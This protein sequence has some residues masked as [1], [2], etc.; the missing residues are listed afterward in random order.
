MTRR[1]AVEVLPDADAVYRTA[2]ESLVSAAVGAVEQ[3]G[4]FVVVLAG[5]STPRDLHAIL[6]EPPHR[7]RVPWA[8]TWVLFGDERCVPPDDP[9]SNYRMA[10][11]T[12]LDRVPVPSEQILR[13]MGEARDPS[14]AAAAY[15]AEIRALFPGASEPRF[16]LVVLGMG[17]DGHTAS[18]FPGTEAL[19][20][21]SRWVVA[22]RIPKLETWRI[23]L[24]LPALNA[25]RGVMLLVT[26]E[27]KAQV[28]AEAFCGAPH[29]APHPC[30]LI[31]PKDGALEV[32]ADRAAAARCPQGADRA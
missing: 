6:A 12:L 23:T 16:D 4:R 29:P 3:R 32:L 10:M 8:R 2:A 20:E 17:A 18:L 14:L 1:R 11:E 13:M 30:E 22:N 9:R 5:G 15:E 21:T 24:T 28:F 26:G 7:D 25:A 19:T 31:V 27:D